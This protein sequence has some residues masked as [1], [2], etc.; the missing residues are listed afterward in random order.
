MIDNYLRDYLVAEGHEHAG[1]FNCPS[2]DG[3]IVGYTEEG[4]VVYD[5]ELMVEEYLSENHNTT[6]DEAIDFINYNT[7]RTIP[8]M[9][10]CMVPPIVMYPVKKII[11]VRT[12]DFMEEKK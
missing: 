6:R 4:A 3:A 7:I 2:Y 1:V 9:T 10:D 11:Q 12:E 5:F 8:Y